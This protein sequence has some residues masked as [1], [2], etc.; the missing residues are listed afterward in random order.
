MAEQMLA[1]LR[2]KIG[3]V[4]RAL[5]YSDPAHFTRAF[6]RWTGLTP[7]DFRRNPQ[8]HAAPQSYRRRE[9]AARRASALAVEN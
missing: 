4:A 5:G 1:N 3:D 7:R 9:R 2:D 6:R 8:V